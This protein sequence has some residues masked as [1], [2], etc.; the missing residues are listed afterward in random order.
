MNSFIK[1]GRVIGGI[2][3]DMK[4]LRRSLIASIC[5]FVISAFSIIIAMNFN[6][7]GDLY[8]LA[9]ALGLGLWN[10]YVTLI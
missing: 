5:L 7:N 10:C 4:F 6:I 2:I 9:L 8:C 1:I 3:A